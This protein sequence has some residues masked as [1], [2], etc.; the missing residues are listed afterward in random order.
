MRLIRQSTQIMFK[1]HGWRVDRFVHNYFYF[2]F[3]YPYVYIALLVLRVAKYLTWLKPLG[4]AANVVFNRY[5]SKVI[6]PENTTKILSIDEDIIATQEKN[7]RIVPFK[8]AYKIILQ[9]ADYIVVMDCPCKKAAH[10]NDAHINSCFA[11]GKGLAT[12]WLD[13]CKQKYNARRVSQ[14]EAI[15]L[16]KRLRAADHITQAFF[17]VATGG[18]TGVICNCHPDS[19]VS[20]IATRVAK[21]INPQLTMNADSG[22]SVKRDE[23]ACRLCGTC[24]NVCYFDA[25]EQL[26]DNWIYNKHDCLGCERCQERCPHQAL[27]LYPDPDKTLPL[28]LDMVKNEFLDNNQAD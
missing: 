19:C 7:K 4:A 25:I 8:Y 22:Y 9:E 2:L 5:H 28:D 20:L 15:E 1:K 16:I 10:P 13:H 14:A 23:Q 17:K 26:G 6:T 18:S 24:S 11:V 21:K 3:Y 12:F 27:S